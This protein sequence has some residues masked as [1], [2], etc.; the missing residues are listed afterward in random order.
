MKRL[1]ILML[2]AV[3]ICPMAIAQDGGSPLVPDDFM[4]GSIW[5]AGSNTFAIG[6]MVRYDLGGPMFATGGITALYNNGA[7][8]AIGFY[9]FNRPN[10]SIGAF[11][12]PGMALLTASK[13][14][15]LHD[16]ITYI[17]G[18]TGA[19]FAWRPSDDWPGIAGQYVYNDPI[20]ENAHNA[21]HSAFLGIWVPIE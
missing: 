19:F 7:I 5:D 3:L 1:M 20:R 11:G 18:Q 8:G 10:F 15:S 6:G 9:I 12:G 16:D 21:G 2:A 17:E 13:A 14:D 4:F